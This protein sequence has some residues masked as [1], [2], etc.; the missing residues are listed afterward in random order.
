MFESFERKRGRYVPPNVSAAK[1]GMSVKIARN[2][3]LEEG[4][5]NEV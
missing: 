4:R 5:V 1:A 3:I 2:N